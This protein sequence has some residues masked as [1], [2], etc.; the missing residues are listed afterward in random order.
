MDTESMNTSD[1]V[2]TI[3][4]TEHEQGITEYTQGIGPLFLGEALKKIHDKYYELIL[5]YMKKQGYRDVKKCH[6][7]LL[8]GTY[9]ELFATV[10]GTADYI[11]ITQQACGK[12]YRDL[13]K[14]GLIEKSIDESD[15]RSSQITLTEKGG[16]AAQHLIS[17]AGMATAKF[18]EEMKA[19]NIICPTEIHTLAKFVSEIE[20][21]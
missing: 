20:E 18:S 12:H 17:A 14:M 1:T 8:V 6:I 4:P 19:I 13:I 5:D 3:E 10:T 9:C 15:K 7:P 2:S 16:D 11:N 21:L